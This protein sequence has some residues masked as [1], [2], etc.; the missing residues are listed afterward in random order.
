MTMRRRLKSNSILSVMKTRMHSRAVSALKK[1]E[2]SVQSWEEMLHESSHHGYQEKLTVDLLTL[3]KQK[4][5]LQLRWVL[6]SQRARSRRTRYLQISRWQFG[7]DS[8]VILE[9]IGLQ[10]EGQLDCTNNYDCTFCCLYKF[11]ELLPLFSALT[12]THKM[13]RV[14]QISTNRRNCEIRCLETSRRLSQF[15]GEEMYNV[16]PSPFINYRIYMV[17][18]E[19]MKTI[20]IHV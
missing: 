2:M 20:P 10:R 14:E 12:L 6:Q 17:L 19:T 16:V 1:R 18:D 13:H 11:I 9:F 4:K 15:V 8:S 5:T 7:A 3:L